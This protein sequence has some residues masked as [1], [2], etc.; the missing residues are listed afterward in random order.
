[1]AVTAMLPDTGRPKIL[2]AGIYTLLYEVDY[3]AFSQAARDKVL[4]A[5]AP[6]VVADRY[7]ALYREEIERR[8]S[9]S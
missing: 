9:G 2:P 8:R 6:E 1:M 4:S 7:M 5:Y 3:P